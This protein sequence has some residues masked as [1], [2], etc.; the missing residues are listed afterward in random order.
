MKLVVFDVLGRE[1]RTL[2]NGFRPA[3]VYEAKFDAS[4][5]SS[6]A[7]FYKIQA[8]KFEQLKKMMIIK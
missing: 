3:G 8:G 6:G 2:V 4:D 7:Y 5:F 1:V